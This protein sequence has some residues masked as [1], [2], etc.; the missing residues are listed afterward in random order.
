MASELSYSSPSR[1]SKTEDE[2]IDKIWKPP[3]A[4]PPTHAQHVYTHRAQHCPHTCPH[5]LMDTHA[6][7]ELS[8]HSP[9]VNNTQA[10]N[11]MSHWH[12]SAQATDVQNPLPLI[13]FP[14]DEPE[15]AIGGQ[16]FLPHKRMV[17]VECLDS[18]ITWHIKQ[19]TPGAAPVDC[20]TPSTVAS[21]Q[22]TL[23]LPPSAPA[24]FP[25]K[26]R[27]KSQSRGRGRWA[28]AH[29]L[30]PH[31]PQAQ[32]MAEWSQVCLRERPHEG[33]RKDSMIS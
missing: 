12:E 17:T 21:A 3:T 33:K 14:S 16:I 25:T 6:G 5:G 26:H 29:R 15:N 7:L 11:L 4:D 9:A 13:S 1:S 30:E 28:I 32:Q 20:P 31:S 27:H 22:R 24:A 10:G 8:R 2:T 18:I 23:G 19:R